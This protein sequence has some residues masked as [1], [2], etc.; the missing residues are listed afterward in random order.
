MI[1]MKVTMLLLLQI[2]SVVCNFVQNFISLGRPRR[3]KSKILNQQDRNHGNGENLENCKNVDL[4]DV[5]GNSVSISNADNV[6]CNCGKSCKGL[7]GLKSNQ[8]SCRLIKSLNDE[9]LY[10][11]EQ[12]NDV[13]IETLENYTIN[14]SP[15]LKPGVYLPKSLEDWNLANTFFTANIRCAH[16][17]GR[18]LNTIVQ[19][20]NTVNC[21]YFKT[22][23]GIVK[24]YNDQ[25]LNRSIQILQKG[26]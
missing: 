5:Q 6:L 26:N 3:C 14:G 23:F 21:D 16:I 1:I 17:R 9:L 24:T 25:E 8:R 2:F 7:R 19:S 10:D 4:P 13:Q 12:V 18:D 20:F 11:I 22:N 15:S